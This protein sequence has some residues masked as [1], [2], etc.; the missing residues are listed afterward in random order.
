MTVFSRW[1]RRLG[2]GLRKLY[3]F[4]WLALISVATL[5]LFFS[6]QPVMTQPLGLA[7]WL[8]K[9]MAFLAF[10]STVLVVLMNA[11]NL[12]FRSRDQQR[13]VLQSF[14]PRHA[15]YWIDAGR[16]MISFSLIQ[17]TH[18]ILKAY[19]PLINSGNFDA[20]LWRLNSVLGA[21]HDPVVMV[22]RLFSAPS[23]HRAFDILY[24]SIYFLALWAGVIVFFAFLRGRSRIR[25]FN[26]FFVMW[27]LGLLLYVLLPSWGPVFT[28]P[29]LFQEILM[30]M[31][32]TVGVQR[33]LFL[34]TSSL[35]A[36]QYN[37]IIRFFGLAAFPSLHV[38]VFVL[39]SLWAPKVGKVWLWWNVVLIPLILIGS[40]LT[41]YHYLIDGL[42]GALVAACAW[43]IGKRTLADS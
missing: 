41:G 34:E 28:R 31:P 24:S 25:F 30:N 5:I 15:S 23:V 35:V 37:V 1:T 12:I 16:I 17:T 26:S 8:F 36:G 32:T 27:Q 33:Q 7:L 13:Q 18:L 11:W 9:R 21:G 2:K 39:Y 19:I 40:M 42:V 20:L 14:E 3:L 29:E 10:L 38:A 6:T 43:V 22:L 4:E